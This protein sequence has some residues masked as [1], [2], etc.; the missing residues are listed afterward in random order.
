MEDA[1]ADGNEMELA[2]RNKSKRERTKNASV[3]VWILDHAFADT[4]SSFILN[5]EIQSI[6]VLARSLLASFAL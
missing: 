3:I 2:K 4:F 5:G 1:D 6:S